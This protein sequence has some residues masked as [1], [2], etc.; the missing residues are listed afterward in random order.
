VALCHLYF[1]NI[2]FQHII[3]AISLVIIS[4]ALTLDKNPATQLNPE[5][6]QFEGVE[7]LLSYLVVNF[8][9]ISLL[10]GL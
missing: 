2:T 3:G 4:A 10:A 7:P 6:L 5:T 8:A 1:S 9:S